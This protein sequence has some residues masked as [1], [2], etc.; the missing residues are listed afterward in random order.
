MT[1][2]APDQS[3]LAGR[4]RWPSWLMP[5]AA[6]AARPKTAWSQPSAASTAPARGRLADV[7][8]ALLALG[9]LLI[10][11]VGYL[12]LQTTLQQQAFTL[13][14]LHSTADVL[15][16][17]ESYLEAGLAARTTPLE[18]ARAAAALGMV[19]NPYGTFIDV[20][21]GQVT[22]V[23]R[24][25]QGQELPRLAQPAAAPAGAQN[26]PAGAQNPA[27][28][29]QNPAAAPAAAQNPAAGAH[30]LASPSQE[31]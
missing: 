26:P 1:V 5:G 12:F 9:L 7:S 8:F 16:A 21:T 13:N 24:P 19:A 28:G 22:G 20:R 2:L 11:M 27:A 17:R 6:R 10:G 4:P 29:A 3:A 15:S 30:N 23:G 14:S 18:L 31:G 25:V